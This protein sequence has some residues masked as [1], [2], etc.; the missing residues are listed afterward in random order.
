MAA[1]RD[2]TVTT[3]MPAISRL[4][5]AQNLSPCHSRYFSTALQASFS[6][7]ASVLG[8]FLARFRRDQR[9]WQDGSEDE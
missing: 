2:L 9:P 6:R 1:L 5:L 4:A 3:A 8:D 7:T